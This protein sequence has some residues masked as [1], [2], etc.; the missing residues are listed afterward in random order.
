MAGVRET[1]GEVVDHG[2]DAQQL[3]DRP[4]LRITQRC[5]SGYLP[6]RGATG[7]GHR[8]QAYETTPAPSPP[9]RPRIEE[10]PV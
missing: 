6:T 9:R 10:W 3:A 1:P 8:C 4:P 2:G 5:R 7:G